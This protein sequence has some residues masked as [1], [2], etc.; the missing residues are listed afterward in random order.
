MSVHSA[1]K[2][3]KTWDLIAFRGA[4]D[5]ASPMSS[6]AH[7]AILLEASRLWIISPRGKTH[8]SHWVGF[9]VVTQLASSQDYVIDQLL[10]VGVACLSFREYFANEVNGSLDR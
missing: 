10:D 1:T 4:K 3:T 8:H 9:E 6:T 2:S 7:L 5:R